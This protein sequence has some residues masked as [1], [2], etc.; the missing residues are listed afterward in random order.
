MSHDDTT[1]MRVRWARLRFSIIGPL[2]AA[3]PAAGELGERLQELSAKPYQHPTTKDRVHFGVS[4]LE[5][6][7][8]RVKDAA[9]PLTALERKVPSQAGTHPSVASTLHLA[10]KKQYEQHPRW[11]YQL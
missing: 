1:P 8:Y 10:I 7:Y 11:S 4:T 6:W 9:D 3:P 2:L 5:R